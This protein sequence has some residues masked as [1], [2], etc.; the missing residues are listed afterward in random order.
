M[1]N[2]ADESFVAVLNAAVPGVVGQ[3]EPRYLEEPRGILQGAAGVLARP[4]TVGEISEIMRL[5][6]DND[7][8]VVPY[9]GGTGLVG[10][11]VVA[12]N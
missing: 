2:P 4:C 12:G 1:L 11:Q 3:L 9:G 6:S 10:G 5:C 7:V 8:A